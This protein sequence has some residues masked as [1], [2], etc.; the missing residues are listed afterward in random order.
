MNR[1][2]YRR[3]IECGAGVVGAGVIGGLSGKMRHMTGKQMRMRD[4]VG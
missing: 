2:G 4:A 1:V 3:G